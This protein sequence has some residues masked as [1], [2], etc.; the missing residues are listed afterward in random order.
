MRKFFYSIIVL[1]FILPVF[2]GNVLAESSQS[3]ILTP[4]QDATIVDDDSD[5]YGNSA[6]LISRKEDD[7]FSSFLIKFDFGVIPSN[8]SIQSAKLTLTQ[9]EASGEDVTINV[10]KVT[11]SWVESTVS[12]TNKPNFD[13]GIIYGALPVDDSLGQKSFTQDLSD[14]VQNWVSDS[15]SNFGFYFESVSE[16]IYSHGFGSRES[17]SK[18]SFTVTY[19]LP[20]EDIPVIS[21]I[22]VSEISTSGVKIS[23]QTNEDATSFV[24]Y[25][26]TMSY[27]MVA[28]GDDLV[29][30]HVVEIG[31]LKED[32]AYHF[33]VSCEDEAGNKVQSDD[34][35]FQTLKDESVEEK[36]QDSKPDSKQDAVISDELD[37][38]KNLKVKT[39]EEDGKH[40]V[41]LN[42]EHSTE[43]DL[44]GYRIFRS[45]ED[46]ISYILITE[47]GAEKTYYKDDSVEEGKTYFYVIRAVKDGKESND[48]NEEVITIF[49]NRIEEEIHKFNFW[50]GFLLLNVVILPVFGLWYFVFRKKA[51]GNKGNFSIFKKKNKINKLKKGKG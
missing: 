43:Q 25:G 17:G 7:S 49:K 35:T 46:R 21:S 6:E 36:E 34:M 40:F 1:V 37:P 11:S 3:I 33:R 10:Y 31:A 50:K 23:W 41:E 8:A 39:G 18:P 12:G 5:N 15:G 14:I 28:G 51:K 19:T 47:V 20:D 44:D 9:T 2:N 48:S 45:E 29:T 30:A 26:E 42:W 22:T 24:E 13:A 27:G 4:S 32:T 16:S 38:P